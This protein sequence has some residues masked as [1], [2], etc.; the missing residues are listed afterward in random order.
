MIEQIIQQSEVYFWSFP[1]PLRSAAARETTMFHRRLPPQMPLFMALLAMMVGSTMAIFQSG[2]TIVQ[3]KSLCDRWWHYI[4]QPFILRSTQQNGCA[5]RSDN[6]DVYPVS[7]CRDQPL[8]WTKSADNMRAFLQGFGCLEFHYTQPGAHVD[9]VGVQPGGVT[10]RCYTS[11]VYP[12]EYGWWKPLQ[13]A[14]GQDYTNDGICEDIDECQENHGCPTYSSCKNTNTNYE[15]HC[16]NGFYNPNSGQP[17][18]NVQETC[19]PNAVEFKTIEVTSDEIRWSS[20]D[21]R[22]RVL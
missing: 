12:P 17:L 21:S 20:K 6:G 11:R 13:C 18:V 10:E 16:N 7:K 19:V 1:F 14:C 22:P 4:N 8:Y 2:R 15:C 9:Y 5:I 3:R